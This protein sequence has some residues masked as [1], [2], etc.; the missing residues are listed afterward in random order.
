MIHSEVIAVL[1]VLAVVFAGICGGLLEPGQAQESRRRRAL[2]G[3]VSAIAVL[4]AYALL[5][6]G[7][8]LQMLSTP[9]PVPLPLVEVGAGLE[10]LL[11]LF[12]VGLVAGLLA[13][14]LLRSMRVGLMQR[15]EK[16][17]GIQG[18]AQRELEAKVEALETAARSDRIKI[19]ILEGEAQIET[20]PAEALEKFR[21]VRTLEPAHLTVRISIARAYKRLG[22]LADALQELNS[23]ALDQL[24]AHTRGVLLWNRA[25]YRALAKG[26]PSDWVALVLKDLEESIRLRPEFLA[27]LEDEHDLVEFR[28]LQPYIDWCAKHTQ[29]ASR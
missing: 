9:K 8:P 4:A 16:E 15:L 13:P 3:A 20:R 7:A 26:E 27:D 17:L 1:G 21:T 22:R 5:T 28:A 29:G 19:L 14:A 10:R 18:D 23:P 24:P 25:C 2:R 12:G 11:M 6:K